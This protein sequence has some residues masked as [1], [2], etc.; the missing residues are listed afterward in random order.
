MSKHKAT[1]HR[2]MIFLPCG[3]EIELVLYKTTSKHHA[4]TIDRKNCVHECPRMN[5]LPHWELRIAGHVTSS[6]FVKLEQLDLLEPEEP[7]CAT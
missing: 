3:H 2:Y 4:A 5:R 6:I 1:I 7:T